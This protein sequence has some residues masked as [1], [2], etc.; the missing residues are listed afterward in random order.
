MSEVR[1]Q[2]KLIVFSA[3]SGT[4]KS[5]ISKL[6]LE[7][8]PNI[9]F[10]VSATTRQKRPGEENGLNYYFLTKEEFE[11]KID[12][13]GFIEH[14][15]FFGNH[16]GTL[17]DK[18]LEV[19]DSGINIL[20]DLDVMGAL[21]LKKLFPD[22]SLLLFIKPPSMDVLRQ[23][24]KGR[25]SEDEESLKARLERAWLELGYANQFDEVVVND[26][27]DQAVDTVTAIITK[28]LSNT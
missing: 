23:R 19:I 15:F 14:E 7:R 8:I 2:G 27:L 28:F 25:D 12:T 11:E 22:N 21:N 5:T 26:T 16:Y 10:S 4:G 24:L 17:L 13:G 20:L 3:P 1:R 9:R 18:T 6:I